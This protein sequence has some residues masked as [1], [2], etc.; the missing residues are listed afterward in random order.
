MTDRRIVCAS[1]GRGWALDA[2]WGECP[3]CG[4]KYVKLARDWR[5]SQMALGKEPPDMSQLGLDGTETTHPV[6]RPQRLT[7]RQRE[8]VAYMRARGVVRPREI[9]V[10]MHAGRTTIASKLQHASSDGYDALR[11]LERRGLVEHVA[12]GAWKLIEH[13]ESWT[14]TST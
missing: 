4:S 12:R 11:R 8:L 9:G 10:L 13:D 2:S 1:C 5:P 3:T 14:T 6:T 7:E